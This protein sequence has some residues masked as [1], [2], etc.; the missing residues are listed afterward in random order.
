[1]CQFSLRFY[2]HFPD[3][4]GYYSVFILDCIA[5]KDD[6]DGGD[7]WSYKMCKAPVKSSPTNQ[8][9]AIHRPDALSVAKPCQS[10][11][12]KPDRNAL[13]DAACYI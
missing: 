7:N 3:G 2:G 12:G 4:P 6:G 13:I 5:D 1:M 11:Q 9:P 10:R 8:R